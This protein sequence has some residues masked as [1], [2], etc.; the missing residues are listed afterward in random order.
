[1]DCPNVVRLPAFCRCSHSIG[2]IPLQPLL[3]S[4]FLNLYSV[5]RFSGFLQYLQAGV[6]YIFCS[7][8]LQY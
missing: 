7:D 1:M 5:D 6:F 2:L 3:F 4:R 8:I